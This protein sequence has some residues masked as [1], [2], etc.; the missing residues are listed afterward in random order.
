MTIKLSN[1]P[2]R[3]PRDAFLG[4]S[5]NFRR[6]YEGYAVDTWTAKAFLQSVDGHL[7]ITATTDG[8]WFR[9]D[10]DSLAA[11]DAQSF[12][13][14]VDWF[15]QLS[16]GTDLVIVERGIIRIWPN[17]EGTEATDFRSNARRML[18]AVEAMLVGGAISNDV[19]NYS[20]S[21]SAGARQLS[22]IPRTELLD[23]R[24]SLRAEVRSE[25]AQMRAA[26]GRKRGN[27]VKSRTGRGGG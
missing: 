24:E 10:D 14:D 1:L 26:S 13:G 23:I 11:D 21:T 25:K 7:T 5:L 27:L 2:K 17:P 6:K 4:Q 8:G 15:I 3:V 22:R 18:D 20:I 9:F 16:S 12:D 19:Q